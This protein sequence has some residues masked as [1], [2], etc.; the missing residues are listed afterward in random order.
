MKV[1]TAPN[2]LFYNNKSIFLAGSIEQDNAENWQN[3]VIE[4]FKNYEVTLFNP[5]REKWNSSWQQSIDNKEF[6]KQVNWELEALE[7]CDFIMMYFDAKTKSPVSMLELGLFSR[8]KKMFVCCPEGF[9]RKGNIDIVCNRY[10][11]P[12]YNSLKE[13]I[14]AIKKLLRAKGQN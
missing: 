8:S 14:F 4:E 9:W 10:N 3:N 6:S 12:Q 2:K 7:K 11:I 5:R 1:I 13:L